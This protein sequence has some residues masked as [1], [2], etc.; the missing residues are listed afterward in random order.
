MGF[1]DTSADISVVDRLASAWSVRTIELLITTTLKSTLC[2]MVSLLIP[3]Q[4]KLS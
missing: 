4:A 3:A 1:T 2:C